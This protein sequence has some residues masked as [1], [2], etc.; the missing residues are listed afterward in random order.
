MRRAALAGSMQ[1]HEVQLDATLVRLDRIIRQVDECLG[2][3]RRRERRTA[4]LRRRRQLA[5]AA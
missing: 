3:V 5:A 1:G 4:K 2:S